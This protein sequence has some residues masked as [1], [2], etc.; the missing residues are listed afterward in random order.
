MRRCSDVRRVRGR[1]VVD[2]CVGPEIERNGCRLRR[3]A[4][5]GPL[6]MMAEENGSGAPAVV[7]H[8]PE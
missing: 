3:R 2:S 6:V 7:F 5:C 8:S 4:F 1:I